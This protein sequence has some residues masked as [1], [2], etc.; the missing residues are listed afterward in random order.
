MSFREPLPEGC[1]PEVAEVLVEPRDVFRL[2]STNPP[3]DADFR[4]QRALNPTKSYSL[5]ECQ[6]RGLS[7]HAELA[8]SVRTLKLPRF[9]KSK[10]CRVSLLP[11]AGYLQQTGTPSHH[12]WWPLAAFDILERCEVLTL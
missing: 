9:R 3:I 5:S 2:V 7:V 4:S 6:T 12:T 1:P 8:D 11:G 10:V